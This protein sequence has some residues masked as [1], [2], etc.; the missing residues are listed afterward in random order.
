[1]RDPYT[2]LGANRRDDIRALRMHY[3]RLSLKLHPDKV[4]GSA[5]AFQEL[6]RAF[7]ILSDP[8]QRSQWE[9]DARDGSS[10]SRTS[11]RRHTR[12]SHYRDED[13]DDLDGDLGTCGYYLLL[14]AVFG[15]AAFGALILLAGKATLEDRISIVARL[16]AALALLPAFAFASRRRERLRATAGGNGEGGPLSVLDAAW[17][18]LAI[19]QLAGSA[20]GMLTVGVLTCIG[21]A[22]H[23]FINAH[24]SRT[25]PTRDGGELICI[26]NL[27]VMKDTSPVRPAGPAAALHG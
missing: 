20:S 19:A 7:E 23:V 21:R 8:T 16:N 13:A 1:M 5:E 17:V 6:Q 15:V 26:L 14:V 18:Q 12:K 4:G 22:C 3:R 27:C 25:F 11:T 24:G 9:R 2:V 10:S